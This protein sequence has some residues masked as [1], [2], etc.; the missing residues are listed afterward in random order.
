M[1]ADTLLEARALDISYSRRSRGGADHRIVRDVAFSLGQGEVLALVGESGSGKTTVARAI[2]G[3]VRFDGDLR[4]GPEG[5][6]LSGHRS[7]GLR[8][9]IQMVFQ[10]PRSSLNPRMTV[11]SIVREAWR[12]HPASAP[13]G[14]PRVELVRLLDRV[15]LPEAV[16][17]RRP[18]QLS[19]GQC[20][21]VSIARAL[22]LKPRLI[23][24]DEAV[25]A[26]DVSVQ[27][28]ILRLLLDLKESFGISLLFITHDLG[29]VRQIADSVAVMEKGEIV[30]QG[31][32]EAV[33]TAPRHSY[34]RALLGAALDLHVD[35]ATPAAPTSEGMTE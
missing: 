11:E 4:F 6:S 27:A 21:R 10:D 14:D 22:A 7:H 9:Q 35:D 12:T 5:T 24:C 19:G 2:V 20:Q 18:G 33:F 17:D 1:P 29:V 23:V 8:Q 13:E 32:T 15:G 28:Q 25:S 26:L 3:L 16:L 34:T 31:A 30:E